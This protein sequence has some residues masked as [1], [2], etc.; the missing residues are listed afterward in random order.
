MITAITRVMCQHVSNMII[1]VNLKTANLIFGATNVEIFGN[2]L[3]IFT[4][5]SAE[6]SLSG[7]LQTVHTN[8]N[9]TDSLLCYVCLS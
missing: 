8:S 4:K 5:V 9:I 2:Q 3:E 6:L 1:F 7:I